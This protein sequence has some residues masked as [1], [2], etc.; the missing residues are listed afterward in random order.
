MAGVANSFYKTENID[1]SD[2]A[3]AAAWK[4][5]TNDKTPT[6]WSAIWQTQRE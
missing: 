6:N 5:I 2:P 3:L 1:M 4:D